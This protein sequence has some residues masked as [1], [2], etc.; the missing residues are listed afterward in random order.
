MIIPILPRLGDRSQWIAFCQRERPY[1]FV[2][3]PNALVDLQSCCLIITLFRENM[4]DGRQAICYSLGSPRSLA[5]AW[6]FIRACHFDLAY[7]VAGL[8][9]VYFD[10]NARDQSGFAPATGV[11]I[12]KFFNKDATLTSPW[13][14][15]PLD[16]LS[17]QPRVW[18]LTELC[19][20]LANGQYR[21]LQH[22]P[23]RLAAT[24]GSAR[25]NEGGLDAERLLADLVARPGGW[26]IRCCQGRLL[27][28]RQEQPVFSLLPRLD[29]PERPAGPAR[30]SAAQGAALC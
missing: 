13:S 4:R 1:C 26:R 27:A 25:P 12:R 28:S 7:M 19:R 20:L 17:A 29:E 23:R 3:E 2:R 30:L 16:P 9:K 6:Q 15:G 10:T 18:G 8:E 22:E 24:G 14:L 21:D 11:R 5:P